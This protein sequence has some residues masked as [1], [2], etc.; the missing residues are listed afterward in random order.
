MAEVDLKALASVEVNDA[1]G[2]T[3]RLGEL[4]E[5]KDAVLVFL[6]HFGCVGCAEQVIQLSPRLSQLEELGLSTTLIGNGATEFTAAFIERHALI[7]RKVNVVTNPKRDA[8]QAAGLHRSIWSVLGPA[9]VWGQ[10]RAR[11]AG[12]AG[13]GIQGDEWQQGGLLLLS[14]DGA[15]KLHYVNQRIGDYVEPSRV[16]E[17]ALQLGIRRARERGE[18]VL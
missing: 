5:G 4:F 16:I 7:D 9:A 2:T 14:S 11:G 10:L 13:H 18:P 1:S 12:I 17:V 8:Y 3:L 15:L 6:R